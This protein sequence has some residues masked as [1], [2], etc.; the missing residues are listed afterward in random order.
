MRELVYDLTDTKCS[1]WRDMGTN[2]LDNLSPS[3][4]DAEC[5]EGSTVDDGLTIH[6]HFVFAEPLSN[7]PYFTSEPGDR[8][9]P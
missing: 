2:N 5:C 1:P 4:H 6:E 7:P 3:R 8:L 9:T